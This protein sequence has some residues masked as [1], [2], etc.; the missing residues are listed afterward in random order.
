MQRALHR[1]RTVDRVERD[2]EQIEQ[3]AAGLDAGW[4]RRVRHQPPPRITR[5]LGI[6][7]RRGQTM[8]PIIARIHERMLGS[9]R[10]YARGQGAM[11][12]GVDDDAPLRRPRDKRG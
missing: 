3:D 9:L 12:A 5:T 2:A 1:S 4:R 11:L 6:V 8:L 10:A 7:T